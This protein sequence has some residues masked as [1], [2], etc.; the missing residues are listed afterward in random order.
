ML[1][2]ALS[3]LRSTSTLKATSTPTS[4]PN[5]PNQRSFSDHRL[6]A[7]MLWRTGVAMILLVLVFSSDSVLTY[8]MSCSVVGLEKAQMDSLTN[9]HARRF[10]GL[11]LVV[12]TYILPTHPPTVRTRPSWLPHTEKC[13]LFAGQVTQ[14]SVYVI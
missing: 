10:S 4:K 13:A 11:H 2:T 7:P 14:R 5:L 6:T 1:L 9:V 3:T 8:T 12:W